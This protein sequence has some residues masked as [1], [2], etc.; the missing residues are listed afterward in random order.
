MENRIRKTVRNIDLELEYKRGISLQR[1]LVNGEI[2]KISPLG[3]GGLITKL[4]QLAGYFNLGI[5]VNV[6]VRKDL[7]FSEGAS[8]YLVVAESGMDIEDAVEIGKLSGD[9]FSVKTKDFELIQ[10]LIEIKAHWE[11]AIPSCMNYVD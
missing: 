2:N 9:K 3:R 7:L 10:S 5:D 4:A 1:K 8:N 6:D 11:G